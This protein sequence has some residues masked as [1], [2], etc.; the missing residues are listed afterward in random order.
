[1]FIPHRFRNPTK[2]ATPRPM[3]AGKFFRFASTP[4]PPSP[5]PPPGDGFAA[6]IVVVFE[7]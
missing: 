1:M 2:A 7:V 6:K 3:R 5:V 4:D